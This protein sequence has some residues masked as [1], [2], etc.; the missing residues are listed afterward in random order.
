MFRCRTIFLVLF[1]LFNTCWWGL[2]R[3]QS[4]DITYTMP[5]PQIVDPASN[6]VVGGLHLIK[7]TI[8][9][10]AVQMME[11]NANQYYLGR[12]YPQGGTSENW[13]LT[14]DTKQVPDGQYGLMAKA[15]IYQ[16]APLSTYSQTV[17]VTV[18]NATASQPSDQSQGTTT[19][20]TQTQTTTSTSSKS[21][22]TSQATPTA[23]E[24]ENQFNLDKSSWKTVASITFPRISDNQIDKIEY[25]VNQNKLEYLVFSGRAFKSSQVTLTI[26]SQPIVVTTRADSNGNWEYIFDKPLDPGQHKVEV[27]IVSTT[28][29]KA[30][31]GPF[32]F[33]IARAQASADN[34]T[35]ASLQLIDTSSRA[36]INYLL[37]A[38][39]LIILAV[40]ILIVIRP[41]K[42]KV[43]PH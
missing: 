26:T 43:N 35:G 41:K 18:K 24:L 15:T 32:D 9:A 27:E 2:A 5:T 3:G 25:K 16:G 30:K 42:M 19:P 8:P 28:G 17:M 6:S 34:P 20:T 4:Y 13:Y 36:F 7:I 31:S 10:T 23:Q 37:I 33:L 39:G 22:K 21:T 1:A 14:W 38:G 11:I 40:I 12:A 29:E